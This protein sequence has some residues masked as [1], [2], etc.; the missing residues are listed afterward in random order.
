[1]REGTIKTMPLYTKYSSAYCCSGVRLGG[2]ESR[3]GE[4]RIV[5]EC[6]GCMHPGCR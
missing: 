5:G 2:S 4:H 1:M 3:F 6:V